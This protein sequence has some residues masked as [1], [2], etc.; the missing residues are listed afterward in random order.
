MNTSLFTVIFTLLQTRR[1]KDIGEPEYFML[2]FARVWVAVGTGMDELR[3]PAGL[4]LQIPSCVSTAPET[5]VSYSACK[6]DISSCL[7]Q[8]FP[9]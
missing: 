3:G 6:E 8:D 5:M 1:I 2:L 9:M 4:C 7:K